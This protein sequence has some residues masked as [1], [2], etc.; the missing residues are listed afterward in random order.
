MSKT[1][2]AVCPYC[3]QTIE[4]PYAE[5]M[6]DMGRRSLAKRN[7]DSEHMRSIVRKRY[8]EGYLHPKQQAILALSKSEDLS[9]LTYKQLAGKVG[10]GGRWAVHAAWHH[11]KVLEK[12]GLLTLPRR[13]VINAK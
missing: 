11:V 7:T 9:K 6:R 2:P 10:L 13:I 4:V 1:F 5:A 8:P 12:K 3:Q